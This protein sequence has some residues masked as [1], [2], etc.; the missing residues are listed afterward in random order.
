MNHK[1]LKERNVKKLLVPAFIAATSIGLTAHAAEDSGWFIGAAAGQSDV[2]ISAY[3]EST[4]YKVVAGY[5]FNKNWALGVEYIDM[6][7]FDIDGFP[8]VNA[9]VEIDGFNFFGMFTLPVSE[10]FDLFAKAGAF[11]WDA[12]ASVSGGGLSVSLNDDGT[13]FSWGVGAALNATENVALTLE[14]Q[15]F[16]I[17]GDDIDTITAGLKFSF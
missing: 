6:G 13:D 5:D 14:F 7:D 8:G 12:D 1:G 3:D 2:D 4:T 11:H 10:T 15:R 17:D 9:D 16:D